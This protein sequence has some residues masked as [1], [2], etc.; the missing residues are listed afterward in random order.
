MDPPEIRNPLN[1]GPRDPIRA[2]PV[3]V[4]QNMNLEGDELGEAAFLNH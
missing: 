2:K 1:H 3:L 4:H